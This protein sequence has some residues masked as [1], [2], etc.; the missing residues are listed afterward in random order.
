MRSEADALY[1]LNY[2]F[3]HV[4]LPCLNRDFLISK[5]ICPSERQR[6]FSQAPE[7]MST[8]W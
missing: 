8:G 6:A 3:F 1:Y 5:K 4:V 7:K 2:L